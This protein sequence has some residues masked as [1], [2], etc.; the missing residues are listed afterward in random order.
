VRNPFKMWSYTARFRRRPVLVKYCTPVARECLDLPFFS[1]FLSTSSLFPHSFHSK[2]ES[3]DGACLCGSEANCIRKARISNSRLR[4]T[5]SRR[6][7]LLTWQ[8]PQVQLQPAKRQRYR[9]AYTGY[10]RKVNLQLLFIL[11]SH[12]ER[13]LNLVVD[14]HISQKICNSV[15]I[16][17]PTTS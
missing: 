4:L 9:L 2:R 8:T 5:L 17:Y 7:S 1:L 6:R 13:F 12:I 14:W 3:M 15:S 10:V 16:R 11:L